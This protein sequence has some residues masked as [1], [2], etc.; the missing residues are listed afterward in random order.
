MTTMNTEQQI[1][2]QHIMI[3]IISACYYSNFDKTKLQLFL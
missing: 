1:T 3:I 2:K